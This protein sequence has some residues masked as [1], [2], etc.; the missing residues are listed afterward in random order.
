M[1][2]EERRH[3]KTSGSGNSRQL[4]TV[5]TLEQKIRRGSW[6]RVNGPIANVKMFK[7]LWDQT[8]NGMYQKHIC[9]VYSIRRLGLYAILAP[10]C[11]IL[12]IRSAP[13]LYPAAILVH[14][15]SRHKKVLESSARPAV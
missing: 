10:S 8:G 15:I 13:A 5:V 1:S 12:F 2:Q 14:D 9:G 6:K 3:K 11:S 7:R 4:L